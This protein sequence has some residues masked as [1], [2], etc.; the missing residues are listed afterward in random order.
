MEVLQV[1]DIVKV[2]HIPVL[3]YEFVK[4]KVMHF[5]AGGCVKMCKY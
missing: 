3:E 5:S 1:E 2:K 4:H